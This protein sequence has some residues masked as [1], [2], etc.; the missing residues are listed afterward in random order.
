MLNDN[1]IK[2]FAATD[3]RENSKLDQLV[4]A[5]IDR[6]AANEIHLLQSLL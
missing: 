1:R 2:Y 4:K 6:T 3:Y 5:I